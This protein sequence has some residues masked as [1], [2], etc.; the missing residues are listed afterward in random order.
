MDYELDVGTIWAKGKS[1]LSLKLLAQ[2]ELEVGKGVGGP[3]WEY[4]EQ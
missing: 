3:A 4:V 2:I 1:R